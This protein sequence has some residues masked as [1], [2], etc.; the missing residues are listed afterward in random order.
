MICQTQL[1]GPYLSNDQMLRNLRRFAS[2]GKWWLA[3]CRDIS[4]SENVDAILEPLVKFAGEPEALRRQQTI[5]MYLER[6]SDATTPQHTPMS[7]HKEVKRPSDIWEPYDDS[8]PLEA[9]KPSEWQKGSIGPAPGQDLTLE[10]VPLWKDALKK[11]RLVRDMAGNSNIRLELGKLIDALDQ[12]IESIELL[13]FDILLTLEP[14][15]SLCEASKAKPSFPKVLERKEWFFGQDHI[16]NKVSQSP[17]YHQ[18]TEDE[19]ILSAHYREIVQ[20][21][22]KYFNMVDLGTG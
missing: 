14:T 22:P 12:A 2:S 15:S 11:L 5:G 20:K 16:W 9:L 18:T 8:R 3:L 13:A 17:H 7:C 21:L 4:T 19:D 6:V 10:E 1:A